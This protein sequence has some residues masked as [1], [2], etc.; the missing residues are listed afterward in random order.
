MSEICSYEED[1]ETCFKPADYKVSFSRCGLPPFEER[2]EVYFTCVEHKRKLVR[3]VKRLYRG[4]NIGTG[5]PK[6]KGVRKQ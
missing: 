6:I 5:A 3:D 2:E 1:G 4:L